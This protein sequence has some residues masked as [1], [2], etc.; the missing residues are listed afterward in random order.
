MAA[1][2]AGHCLSHRRH[3]VMD[4]AAGRDTT[5]SQ[6]P[7]GI[8][9]FWDRHGWLNSLVTNSMNAFAAHHPPTAQE[10]DPMLM[11][12]AMTWR[13]IVLYLWHTAKD[14]QVPALEHNLHHAVGIDSTSSAQM[15]DRA[16]Q[17]VLRLMGK[18]SELNSWKVCD[19]PI[20]VQSTCAQLS[21]IRF[22]CFPPL[23]NSTL[24]TTGSSTHEHTSYF[25][26]GAT[27]AQARS[28]GGVFTEAE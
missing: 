1:T 13:A 14:I 5:N 24:N 18:M 15:A 3:A 8:F 6:T 4:T 22:L 12:I 23:T 17:E 26:C 27:F 20:L 10:H 7:H 11:F 25:M 21:F 19:H 16:A 28:Y 9:A 2:V